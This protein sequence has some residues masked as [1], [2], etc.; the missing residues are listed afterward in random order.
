MFEPLQHEYRV[1]SPQQPREHLAAGSL[2]VGVAAGEVMSIRNNFSISVNIRYIKDIFWTSLS[3]M[4]I[5]VLFRISMGVRIS[6][7]TEAVNP[8]MRAANG[9]PVETVEDWHQ[10]D[11]LPSQPRG[12][13]LP[14]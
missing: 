7:A 5:M 12:Q 6:M 1:E 2:E 8:S 3:V 4:H 13:L 11:V 10:V 14:A 9:S